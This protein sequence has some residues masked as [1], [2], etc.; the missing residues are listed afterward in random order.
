M[1]CWTVTQTRRYK[2]AIMGAGISNWSSFHGNSHLHTWDA[3]HYAADPYAKGG[4]YEKFSG[5]HYVKRVRTPTL[6]LHGEEDWLVPLEQAL[7]FY[8]ALRDR[9]VATELVSYQREGHG[10]SEQRHWLDLQ[11]RIVRWYRQYV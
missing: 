2:A 9:G 1:T 11:R 10:I 8:R 7:Q 3:N 4:A 5:I 6:I